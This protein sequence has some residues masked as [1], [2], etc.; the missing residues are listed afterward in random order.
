MM[1]YLIIIFAVAGTLL[2]TGSLSQ[3]AHAV[4]YDPF[5]RVCT[6]GSTDDSTVCGVN[7]T[8][9]NLQSNRIYGKNGILTKVTYIVSIAVGVASVI[10][11][12]IGG[13][14][15]IT[16][17]GDANAITSAKNTVLYA[18]IGIVIAVSAQAIIAVVLNK[19]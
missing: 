4:S 6:G 15:Y 17:G 14:K 7:T 1:K 8:P 3:R 9:Q 5:R 19:L 13:I 11:I 12:I 18:I 16:S 10:V 2:M